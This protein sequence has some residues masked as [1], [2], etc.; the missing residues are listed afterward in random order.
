MF[1][2]NF[3]TLERGALYRSNVY[4]RNDIWNKVLNFISYKKCNRK[5]FRFTVQYQNI[6]MPSV[7]SRGGSGDS[8]DLPAFKNPM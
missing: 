3:R 4:T 8:L 7:G 2:T 5:I 1:L 6:N